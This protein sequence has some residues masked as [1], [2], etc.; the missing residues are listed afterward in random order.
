VTARVFKKGEG[1][2]AREIAGETILVPFKGELASLQQIH[3]LSPVAAFIWEQIDGARSVEAIHAGV[4][5]RFDV[6]PQQARDDL[7]ELIDA[8]LKSRLIEAVEA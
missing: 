2:A 8:L 4:L 7:E 1:L 6:L 5:E 3:V